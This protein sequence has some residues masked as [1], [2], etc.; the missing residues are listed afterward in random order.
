MKWINFLH[1][2][3]PANIELYSI[4][5]AL[6][7]SYYRLLRL[8]EEH[9]N[10]QMTWNVSGCLLVRLEDEN[11]TDFIKRLARLV[12]SGQVELVGSAAYHGFLPL[13]PEA[14]VIRQ[15]KENEKI[16][17]KYFGK[18][19]KPQ[20]FFLPE[21]AYSP[22]VARIVKKLGYK[23]IIL[24]EIAVTA[25]Q[26]PL[27]S[28]K[29]YLDINSKLQIVFRSRNF[30]STYPP[31]SLMM[32]L[33][34]KTTKNK[35]VITAT[36]AELYGLRHEDPTAEMERIAKHKDLETE[37][38]SEFIKNDITSNKLEKIM[39][40][41]CS[42]ESSLKE[43]EK[44]QPFK[45]W[46]DKSNKIHN[47]LWKLSSLALSLYDKYNT[48]KNHAWYYWHLVRGIASCTFWWASARDFSKIFGPYAWSPDGIE[49]G[50]ED[51]IRSVRSLN[52]P[53]TKKDKLE[54]EKYYLKIKKL[55]WE[56]HWKRH[57]KKIT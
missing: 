57:W 25:K 37:T 2:Y 39:L 1:F 55:I 26:K 29:V 17:K 27:Q 3:Q 6:D 45:L 48:D 7:K 11:K 46:H 4:I 44:N 18:N 32:E 28:S 24:D 22:A 31:D 30:S 52:N 5:A 56:E 41:S 23:W 47:N 51:L 16:L 36:D 8:M 50:L 33:A 43:V 34:K 19:C 15:I 12:K 9:P 10:L 40:R 38:I 13:L 53:K 42:W 49:R 14:E 20:G 35:M 21:M 54:A